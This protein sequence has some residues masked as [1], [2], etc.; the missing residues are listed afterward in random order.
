MAGASEVVYSLLMMRDGFVA[1]NINFAGL[2]EDMPR[3]NIADRMLEKKLRVVLSN[4]FGFGG[5]NAC[6]LLKKFEP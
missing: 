6:L 5:T 4:S 1:P 2:S 3:I